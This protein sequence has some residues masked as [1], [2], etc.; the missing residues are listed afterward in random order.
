MEQSRFRIIVHFVV[1]L[2]VSL[3]PAVS[4]K[5]ICIELK[6]EFKQA[7]PDGVLKEIITI[8]GQFP[9]PTIRAERGDIL[10]I[11]V[12]NKLK[13]SS[14]VRHPTSVHFHGIEMENTPWFDGPEQVAQCPI[15]YNGYM[16]YSFKLVQSGTYWY[17]SHHAWQYIDGFWGL[18]IVKNPPEEVH[19]YNDEFSITLMDWHYRSGGTLSTLLHL[20]RTDP[21]PEAGRTPLPDSA[22][23]NG[24]GNAN[25]L[26]VAVNNLQCDEAKANFITVFRVV[27][28]W[29][30]RLRVVNP[31]A[32]ASFRFS[33][34]HHKL[35]VIEVDGVDTVETSPVDV[36]TIWPA[37]RYSFLVTMDWNSQFNPFGGKFWIRTELIIDG[38][39]VP[40]LPITAPY[41]A[42]FYIGSTP[43]RAAKKSVNSSK[44]GKEY[45][46]D[47]L[48]ELNKMPD[49]SEIK[50]SFGGG[51][52]G[53][54]SEMEV[55]SKNESEFQKPVFGLPPPG[56]SSAFLSNSIGSGS[57]FQAGAPRSCRAVG[58]TR[59]LVNTDPQEIVLLKDFF[60][61]WTTSPQNPKILNQADCKSMKKAGLLDPAP[62]SYDQEVVLGATF[63]IENDFLKAYMNGV[64]YNSEES[65]IPVIFRSILNLPVPQSFNPQYIPELQRV[66][67]VVINNDNDGA[68]PW[69]LH[70]HTFWVMAT[71]E[72]NDGPYNPAIHSWKLNVNNG[73]R[74]DTTHTPRRSWTVIR[75]D[76]GNPG[77]WLLHC[78]IHW[79]LEVGFGAV[80]IEGQHELQT[81]YRVPREAKRVCRQNGVII[82]NVNF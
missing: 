16:D 21:N 74:R 49:E 65:Q 9:G 31:S 3:G 26:Q 51:T 63:G 73:L 72:E 47:L 43:I 76:T 64:S 48:L 42:L 55:A 77:A 54:P 37:Q 39:S 45:L 24:R 81:N 52:Q 60:A 1:L 23:L 56:G 14:G 8:N 11:R 2:Y 18:L 50:G 7:S 78:H 75:F 27:Q 10:N 46:A 13:D 58:F 36:V 69:H 12:R 33:I 53:R 17:H 71:G 68:H 5:V 82:P 34:D 4:A 41:A 25:C 61:V 62:L 32:H 35:R 67:Q 57:Q 38:P 70:G 15:P 19:A 29:T 20:P 22:L 59:P 66:I 80:F 40:I 6:A 79:H 44:K 28:G 30:Y